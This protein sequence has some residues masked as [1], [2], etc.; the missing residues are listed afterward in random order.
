MYD[1]NE[2][3]ALR[4]FII[5][6]IDV[7]S[8]EMLKEASH[9]VQEAIEYNEKALIYYVDFIEQNQSETLEL[10]YRLTLLQLWRAAIEIV[11][12]IKTL[13]EGNSCHSIGILLR[14]LFEFNLAVGFICSDPALARKRAVAYIGVDLLK[15]QERLSK[16][17]P[18]D[19][20]KEFQECIGFNII[21]EI[22]ARINI[23]AEIDMLQECFNQDPELK[24]VQQEYDKICRNKRKGKRKGKVNVEWYELFQGQSSIFKL[25]ELQQKKPLY[26]SFYDSTSKKVHATGAM[27]D[28]CPGFLKNPKAPD[29]KQLASE[30]D[31]VLTFLD[32]IGMYI[33]REQLPNLLTS[34]SDAHLRTRARANHFDTEM[35]KMETV[36]KI[37]PRTQ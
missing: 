17:R 5:P 15:R 14:S 27:Y 12:S 32:E 13:I 28:W 29:W 26:I 2:V 30:V 36:V 33:L 11:E 37:V 7:T 34:Y 24:E 9:I 1:L 31:W 3:R 16:F 25:A 8:I 19:C 18:D 23:A 22:T 20:N 4:K 35:E 21:K 10:K 6:D